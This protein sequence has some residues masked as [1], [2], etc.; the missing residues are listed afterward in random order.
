MRQTIGLLA[1]MRIKD[2]RCV[3]YSLLGMQRMCQR[4]AI[5][6]WWG[7]NTQQAPGQMKPLHK[8]GNHCIDKEKSSARLY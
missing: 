2:V 3:I 1:M 7:S 6:R 4:L 8:K 5:E